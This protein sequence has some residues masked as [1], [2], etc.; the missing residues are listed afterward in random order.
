MIMITIAGMSAPIEKAS[1]GWINQMV[2]E[3]RRTSQPLCV[4]VAVQVEGAHVTLSTPACGGGGGGRAPNDRERRIIEEWHRRG[5][6][7]GQFSPG[8]LQ[9]FLRELARLT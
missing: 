7:A 8:E 6:A 9:A 4:Q 3:A 2:A 5:M 1:E